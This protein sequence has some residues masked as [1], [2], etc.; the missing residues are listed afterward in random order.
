MDCLII[1]VREKQ[2]KNSPWIFA[3]TTRNRHKESLIAMLLYDQKINRS[4]LCEVVCFS[5]CKTENKTSDK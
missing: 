4:V 1:F 3:K 5:S 2:N